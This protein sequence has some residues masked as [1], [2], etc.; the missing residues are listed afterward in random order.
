[1]KAKILT[2]VHRQ[3]DEWIAEAFQRD[4]AYCT[5]RASCEVK[6]IEQLK[7]EV[8]Q[9]LATQGRGWLDHWR[10]NALTPNCPEGTIKLPIDLW[11][12]KLVHK[13]C[14][15]QAQVL[16]DEPERFFHYCL[17]TEERKHQIFDTVATGKYNGFHHVPGR[18]LCVMCE[19]KRGNSNFS[20]HYPW[21]LTC[22]EAYYP[23]SPSDW[24]T[25]RSKLR[26][27]GIT[28]SAASSALCA[29]HAVRLAALFDPN[30]G[31]E[32]SVLEFELTR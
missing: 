10:G 2:R 16:L 13:A 12:C 14:P 29:T 24:P 31:A 32:L 11:Y 18:Y 5:V 26:K 30:L 9:A 1:V 8:R 6:A 21:E 28:L 7:T 17:A 20:Y 27:H 22:L 23:I 19:Q 3:R 4:A 25:I 15:T